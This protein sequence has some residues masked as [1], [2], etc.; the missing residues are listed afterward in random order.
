MAELGTMKHWLETVNSLILKKYNPADFAR[1]RRA[2][3]LAYFMY[4]YIVLLVVMSLAA[5]TFGMS[6]FM[7]MALITGPALISGII[8]ILLIRAGRVEVGATIMAYFSC[9]I[10]IA[11]FMTKPPHMAGVSLAYFMYVALVFANVFCSIMISGS[12]LLLFIGAH[13]AYFAMIA[14][15]NASGN[16]IE[17]SRT[18]LVD[19]IATLVLLYMIATVSNKFL[20]K[21]IDLTNEEADIVKNQYQQIKTLNDVIRTISLRLTN[22]VSVT[23]RVISQFTLNSREQA[24]SIE[25]LSAVMERIS[26]DSDQV[27]AA[28]NDQNHSLVDLINGFG[29]ISNLIDEIEKIGE[30]VAAM[31]RSFFE[32]A[33][34]GERSSTQ[35]DSINKKISHNSNQIL[36]IVN[37]MGDFFD[38]INLLSLNATIEAARAGE[39][40]RGFAVVAEEIGKLADNS[41]AELKGITELIETNK[42]D[43]EQG[44]AVI[45]DIISFIKTMLDRVKDLQGKYAIVINVIKKQEALKNNMNVKTSVVMDKTSM[46]ETAMINQKSSIEEVVKSIESTMHIVQNNAE[47]TEELGINAREL[48]EL[49][50]TL[51]E[52]IEE[53]I[54]NVSKA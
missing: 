15:P 49:S 5:L 23:G 2:L 4:G 37:I 39:Q 28:T 36:S 50:D 32:I 48:V 18:T 14:M 12:I 47:N 34:R 20:Q 54:S 13:V 16:M 9:A 24:S 25:E 46:I 35:L 42:M 44:D 53:K 3:L 31:Y 33:D 22:S 40:G 1:Y 27:A 41:A 30:E 19:G 29:E 11:G 38:K 8:I 6:R 21:A 51:K 7:E 52:K 10:T 43:V 26:S 17:T 45:R